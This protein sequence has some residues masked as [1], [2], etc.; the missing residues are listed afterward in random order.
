M[1]VKRYNVKFRLDGV[2][3]EVNNVSGKSV[4]HKDGTIGPEGLKGALDRARDMCLMKFLK[5]YA[6]MKIEYMHGNPRVVGVEEEGAWDEAG[7]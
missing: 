5:S 2:L 1:K 3:V 7:N 6:G 4:V